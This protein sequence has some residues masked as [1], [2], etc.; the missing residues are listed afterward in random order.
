MIHL[1]FNILIWCSTYLFGCL[2]VVA[3]IDPKT[4]I[5]CM[6]F[7]RRSQLLFLW[8]FVC[9]D[10]TTNYRSSRFL[11]CLVPVSYNNKII[12]DIVDDNSCIARFSKVSKEESMILHAD[13]WQIHACMLIY[14]VR[15]HLERLTTSILAYLQ[16]GSAWLSEYKL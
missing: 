9:D 11:I 3:I 14:S 7:W 4:V 1:V 15:R 8:H 6:L 12:F 10:C 16:C 2:S 13:T 5:M